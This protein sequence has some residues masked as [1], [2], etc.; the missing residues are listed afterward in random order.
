ML[1]KG[2]VARSANLQCQSPIHNSN[3]SAV[4]ATVFNHTFYNATKQYIGSFVLDVVVIPNGTIVEIVATKCDGIPECWDEIDEIN[5]G[6]NT[7]MTALI[8]K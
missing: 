2:L 4:V 1:M 3:S 8:G 7:S 5:C 6:F